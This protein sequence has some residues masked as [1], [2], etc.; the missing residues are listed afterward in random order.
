MGRDIDDLNPLF[1][2]KPLKRSSFTAWTDRLIVF[3][4]AEQPVNFNLIWLKNAGALCVHWR[5]DPLVDGMPAIYCLRSLMSNHSWVWFGVRAT[6]VSPPYPL[7]VWERMWCFLSV[8]GMKCDDVR[9]ELIIDGCVF[10]IGEHKRVM[11]RLG[12]ES[13]KRWDPLVTGTVLR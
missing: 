8:L 13:V 12:R 3:G 11:S 9:A 7:C 2:R 10:L 6:T 1:P 5:D 4:C